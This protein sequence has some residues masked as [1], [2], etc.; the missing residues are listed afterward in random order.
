MA[1]LDGVAGDFATAEAMSDW[2]PEDGDYTVVLTK[3]SSGAK[4]GDNAMV[5]FKVV[6]TIDAPQNPEL[7]KKAFTVGFATTKSLGAVKTMASAIAG[8]PVLNIR[9][10]PA[11]VESCVGLVCNV[12]VKTS[13]KGYKNVTIREVFRS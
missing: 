13:A 1:I 3:G 2:M 8:R 7:D 4:T 11:V 9:E 10:V 12:T 5:W 6:G